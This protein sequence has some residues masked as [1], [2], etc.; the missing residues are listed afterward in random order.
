MVFRRFLSA[1]AKKLRSFHTAALRWMPFV[2]CRR[3]KQNRL[4]NSYVVFKLS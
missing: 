1:A 2:Y 4:N 3:V